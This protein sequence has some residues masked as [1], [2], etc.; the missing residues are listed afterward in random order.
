M[1]L[2]IDT[3]KDKRYGE[4]FFG[5]TDHG[6]RR[7]TLHEKAGLGRL[8]E[9]AERYQLEPTEN[10]RKTAAI[11][12]QLSEYFR[13][14]R[15]IFKSK[16]D[17]GYLPPFKQKVLLAAAKIPYGVVASY[18]DVAR[19]AGSPGAARAVG[20]VMASN[21]IGIVIPCHRVIGSNG[22]LVGFGGGDSLKL[23]QR[24]L[25]QEGVVVRDMKVQF[26]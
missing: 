13:G 8:M 23:K 5:V 15:K 1:N 20:Q 25:E 9:H 3:I 26:D 10:L 21:P 14:C 17:V 12:K 7:L 18:G 2:Y 4:V 6:L 19:L 11:K 16:L 22:H 24:L